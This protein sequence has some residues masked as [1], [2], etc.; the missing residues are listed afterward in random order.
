MS[1]KTAIAL[2]ETMRVFADTAPEPADF[3]DLTA[4]RVVPESS[5]SPK[6]PLIAAIAGFALIVVTIGGVVAVTRQST[7]DSDAANAPT[8]ATIYMTPGLVPDGVV[9]AST[10]VWSDGNGTTQSYLAPG[11]S[12]W[13]EGD[14]VAIII[15]SDMVGLGAMYDTGDGLDFTTSDPDT[16]FADIQQQIMSLYPE[17]Q[18]TF[19]KITIRGRPALLGERTLTMYEGTAFEVEDVAIGVMVLEGNGIVSTVD[20]HQMTRGIAIAISESLAPASPDGFIQE[21]R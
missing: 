14:L 21:Q 13:V 15:V 5:R 9:L 12:T 1:D 4:T 10:E 18:V 11:E 16:I 6:S 3:D 20:T 7:T 8:D 17:S 2:R 19:D